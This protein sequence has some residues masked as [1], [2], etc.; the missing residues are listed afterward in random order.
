MNDTSLMFYDITNF[1]FE[2]EN[3]DSN[4]FDN[5]VPLLEKG[6]RKKAFLKKNALTLLFKLA[7]L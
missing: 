3:P 1:Y 7:F 4:L 5:D 2:I 6:L